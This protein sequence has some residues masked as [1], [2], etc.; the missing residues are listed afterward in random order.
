MAA[1]LETLK[2]AADSWAMR[3][4]GKAVQVAAPAREYVFS[5]H[6]VQLAA[7]EDDQ[8]PGRQGT[9][10]AL[11][12]APVA[13]LAVPAGHCVAVVEPRGQKDPTGHSMGAPL[14]Q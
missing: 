4:Q 11:E 1:G 12:V 7:P 14:A 9:Q 3:A 10:V 5:K 8:E 6:C 13:A 2:S